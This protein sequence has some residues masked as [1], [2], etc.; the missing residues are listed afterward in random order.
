VRTD[1]GG[2]SNGQRSI[3]SFD[4]AS[5]QRPEGP[6]SHNGNLDSIRLKV[7]S[8][9]NTWQGRWYQSSA[10]LSSPR[11]RTQVLPS[12]D[13][14]NDREVICQCP[15]TCKV[16]RL[17][18]AEGIHQGDMYCTFRDKTCRSHVEILYVA[19]LLSLDYANQDC[20]IRA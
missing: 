17:A 7:S 2:P 16:N 1:K 6:F 19:N 15:A 11:T 8:S 4:I 14:S 3:L 20:N 18:M 13:A 5:V 12:F 10:I 9:R